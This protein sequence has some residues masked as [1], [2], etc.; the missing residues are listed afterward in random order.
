MLSPLVP[1]SD[2]TLT[3][4]S[5]GSTFMESFIGPL[6]LINAL[7]ISI[8]KEK[9]EYFNSNVELLEEAWQKFDLFI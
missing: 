9:K 8:E 5:K 7:I 1:Y 6:S 3:A 2:V 4:I